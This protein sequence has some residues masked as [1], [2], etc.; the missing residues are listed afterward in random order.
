MIITGNRDGGPDCD[1]GGGGQ[2]GEGGGGVEEGL[3]R[4]QHVV[5]SSFVVHA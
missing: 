3:V 4:R 5:T 2:G 1:R